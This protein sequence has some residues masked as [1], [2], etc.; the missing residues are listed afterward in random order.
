VNNGLDDREVEKIRKE[1]RYFVFAESQQNA[2]VNVF[3]L[4]FNLT[5]LFCSKKINFMR[6]QPWS[7]SNS[8]M[9]P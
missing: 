7:S 5:E 2:T 8:R 6:N 9:E 1:Q 4:G 3:R